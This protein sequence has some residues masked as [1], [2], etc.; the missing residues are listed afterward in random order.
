MTRGQVTAYASP[1]SH[2]ESGS[3]RVGPFHGYGKPVRYG[4]TRKAP[5]P[6]GAVC[7]PYYMWEALRK[8][9]MQAGRGDR[10]LTLTQTQLP[11]TR[12]YS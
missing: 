12:R 3:P 8:G 7:S 1:P 10:M 9:Q 2:A 11:P 5:D 6:G 4:A